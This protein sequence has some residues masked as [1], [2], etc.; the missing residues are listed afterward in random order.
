[1]RR[2][3][4]GNN[5]LLKIELF[6]DSFEKETDFTFSSGTEVVG[7]CSIVWRDQMF[8]FGGGNQKHQISKVENC[9]LTSI[10]QLNFSMNHG[11]CTNVG[12]ELVFICFH[13]IDDSST[14]KRCLKANQPLAPFQAAK[15]SSHPHRD[16]RI[17]NNGGKIIKL[18]RLIEVQ[19][20]FLL[21]EV[22]FRTMLKLSGLM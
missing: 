22:I 9:R 6:E 7:S 5:Y 18:H 15:D 3:S 17:G 21:W 20:K 8:V 19:E 16:T 13:D 10:G 11:A 1:M 12:N 4:T 2:G 14:Y